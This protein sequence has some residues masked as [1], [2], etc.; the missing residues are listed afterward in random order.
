MLDEPVREPGPGVDEVSWRIAGLRDNP[1]CAD[2]E[3]AAFG[4]DDD[5]GLRVEPS[6]DPGEDV[7]APYLN[8]GARPKV[9]VLR[10]QGVNSHVETA[11]AFDRAGFDTYD[12]HMTDLQAGRFNLSD[13]GVKGLVAAGGFS[14]GDTLGAGEGWARSVLYNEALLE[15]L[16]GLLRPRGHLRARHLQRRPDVRRPRRA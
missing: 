5:P 3:H 4:A 2:E 8:I 15:S 1:A 9:A 7:A 10:E 14:Y 6:F 13:A 11:F 16:L 12:V